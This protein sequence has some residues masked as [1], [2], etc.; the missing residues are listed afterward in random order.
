M[1]P[2]Q[3]TGSIKEFGFTNPVLITPTNDIIAGHGRVRA[4]AKLGMELVPCIV[5]EHLTDLQRRAY[6]LADNRIALNS[7]WDEDLL[8]LELKEL[9]QHDYELAALGFNDKELVQFLASPPDEGKTDPDAVPENVETRC[10]PGDLWALG[11]HYECDCG[12]RHE[13]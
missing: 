8:A 13:L 4:A 1:R 7:G 12:E 2:I 9:A 10:K 3:S 5:L 11:G 6:V